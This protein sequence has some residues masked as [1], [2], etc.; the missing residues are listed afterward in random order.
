[1]EN[2][3]KFHRSPNGKRLSRPSKN[4]IP[5]IWCATSTEKSL[6]NY[7]I[8][9]EYSTNFP[10]WL[11]FPW[12]STNNWKNLGISKDFSR[13]IFILF[14][15]L[16]LILIQIAVQMQIF[17]NFGLK[18]RVQDQPRELFLSI[19]ILGLKFVPKEHKNVNLLR[20]FKFLIIPV[21]VNSKHMDVLWKSWFPAN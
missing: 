18:L 8:C 21:K 13:K 14:D 6:L 5:N 9:I 10:A 19:Y 11:N 4:G 7:S 2:Y 15:I 20:Y 17:V 16:C 12:K 3:P 1:M